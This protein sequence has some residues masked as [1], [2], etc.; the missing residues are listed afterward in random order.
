[1]VSA[2]CTLLSSIFIILSHVSPLNCQMFQS[3]EV[4]V[5]KYDLA[6]SSFSDIFKHALESSALT[7][8]Y[9]LSGCAVVLKNDGTVIYSAS[10]IFKSAAHSDLDFSTDVSDIKG[11]TIPGYTLIDTDRTFFPG[12]TPRIIGRRLQL[13]YS[14]NDIKKNA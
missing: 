7:E 8:R 3:N 1:M 14:K 4:L 13:K 10:I 2:E 6:A 5:N 11:L 12:V 9:S